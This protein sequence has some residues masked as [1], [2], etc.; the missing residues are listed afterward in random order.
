MPNQAKGTT[1]DAS[2]HLNHTGVVEIFPGYTFIV[3]LT[4]SH[5]NLRI[6]DYGCNAFATGLNA[7]QLQFKTTFIHPSVSLQQIKSSFMDSYFQPPL[8]PCRGQHFQP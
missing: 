1:H 2:C 4:F 6:I 8:P 7:I 3:V 5:R